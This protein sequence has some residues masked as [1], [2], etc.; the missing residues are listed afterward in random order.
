MATDYVPEEYGFSYPPHL[1]PR[2]AI[3][4]AVETLVE[5]LNAMDGEADFEE[6]GAE[7]SFQSHDADGPGCPVADS[8][9]GNVDDVG[10]PD[11]DAEVETWSHP[12]DHPGEL[13]IGRRH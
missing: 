7:D 2:A 9:G 10:E 5:V 8:G 12:D 4:A 13:F 1:P 11:H 3:E 6:T